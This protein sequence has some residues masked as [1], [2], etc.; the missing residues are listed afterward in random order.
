M[1]IVED[2]TEALDNVRARQA[3]RSILKNGNI[4][5]TNHA[6]GRMKQRDVSEVDVMN[7]LRGGWCD[8]CEWEND[9]WRYQ[10]CTHVLRVVVEIEIDENEVTVVTV[11]RL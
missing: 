4:V 2:M 11:I 7:A 10:I 6:I 5:F 1:V 8:G 3:V 9:A